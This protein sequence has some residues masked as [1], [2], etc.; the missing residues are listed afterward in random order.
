MK[1][2]NNKIKY[3]IIIILSI[4]LGIGGIY[5][6][7]SYSERIPIE[8]VNELVKDKKK[9]NYQ[10]AKEEIVLDPYVNKLPEY[11]QQY[12]NPQIMGRLEVPNMN[13]DALITRSENNEYYLNYNLNN[14]H[15]GLGVPFFDYR[16]TD[17]AN[18]RQINIYGHNTQ[19]TQFTHMLPFINLEAYIDKNIF[20]NYK[21]VFLSIDEKRIEYEIVAVKI[22]TDGNPEHMKLLFRD[23]DDY[24]NHVVKM[25]SN[26]LYQNKNLRILPNDRLLVLQVCHY[27]P[28]NSYLLVICREKV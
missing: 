15:D 18:N 7:N 19:N 12:N 8:S 21:T 22:L 5:A 17:L 28:P 3:F 16:N 20:D 11:R 1:K 25:L 24:L 6:Y 14:Q 10:D 27:N 9:N 2:R 4:I 13:I 23:D 26:S